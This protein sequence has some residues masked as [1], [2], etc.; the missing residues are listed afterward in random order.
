M[1][2]ILIVHMWALGDILMG[3]PLLRKVRRIYPDSEIHWLVDESNA[4]IIEFNPL[5]DEVISFDAFRWRKSLRRGA[6]VEYLR[7]ILRLRSRLAANRYDI[8]LNLTGDKLWTS[9]F[10]LMGRECYGHFHF[11]AR[12]KWPIRLLYKDVVVTKE[13]PGRH[14]TLLYL[15]VLP[16]SAD[17]GVDDPSI[18]AGRTDAHVTLVT[19]AGDEIG[20][21]RGG[22]DGRDH[23]LVLLSPYSTWEDRNWED[24]RYTALCKWV[25]ST[26]DAKVI[27]AVSPRDRSRGLA[28]CCEAS[29]ARV[30]LV[31][32]STIEEYKA[33]IACS[34]LIV[35][36]DSSAMHLAAAFGRPY[37]ALFG[38]TPTAERAPLRGVGTLIAKDLAC[39]PCD[40]KSCTNPVFRRCMKL[41][42]LGEVQSA[43]A[44]ALANRSVARA[45]TEYSLGV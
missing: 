21:G 6:F 26:Y 43:V 32:R 23:L 42:E 7:T 5:I 24:E 12:P 18:V 3:T 20:V 16:D 34:D 4:P 1:K 2:R 37:V 28:L 11:T 9:L 17:S 19:D 13:H 27:V 15:D 10:L 40:S 45:Q 44:A 35:C 8:I 22:S 39:S 14:N 38:P 29:D 41:I 30:Q 36:V 31:S 33:L 25:A